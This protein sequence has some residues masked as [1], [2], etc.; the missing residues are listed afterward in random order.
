MNV[1]RLVLSALWALPL[2]AV[3]TPELRNYTCAQDGKSGLVTASF[4]LDEPAIVTM[5]VLTNGVPV[6]WRLYRDGVSGVTLNRVNPAKDYT[7]TW[8][9]SD[10]W[11]SDS[12]SK[13]GAGVVTVEMR[14]WSP[15]NPPDY[16]DID[17]TA[18]SN[19]TYYVSE[20]DLPYAVTDDLY[21]TTHLLMKRM[22]AANRVWQMGS[23]KDGKAESNIG[24]NENLF[25]IVLSSDYYIGVYEFTQGQSVQCGFNVPAGQSVVGDA[26]PLA[27]VTHEDI[28]AVW[29]SA[30]PK[31]EHAVGSGLLSKIQEKT[32]ILVDLPTEA[33]WEFACRGGTTTYFPDGT[34]SNAGVGDYAI[35]SGNAPKDAS[36]NRTCAEVGTKDP[37]FYGLYDMIGN[38]SEFCVEQYVTTYGK[39]FACD[40]K[41]N[42]NPNE[43]DPASA[44]IAFRGSHYDQNKTRA[45]DGYGAWVIPT[46]S[47]YRG[48]GWWTARTS[49]AKHGLRLVAPV[50]RT[51]PK[52]DVST[53]TVSQEPSRRVVIPYSLESTAIVTLELYRNGTRQPD[54]AL[55][56]ICGDVNRLVE[57]DG[58]TKYIYWTPDD[59]WPRQTLATGELSFKIRMWAPDNPPAYMSL[60]LRQSQ[61]TNIAYYA[62]AE[63]MPE[64]ITND[65][66]KTDFLVMRRIPAKDVIWWMGIATN[67]Q[68]KS[69]ED[70]GYDPDYSKRHRVQLSQDF[71]IGV[72][73]LT[74][75]QT[76]VFNNDASKAAQSADW[77]KPFCAQFTALRWRGD[78]GLDWPTDG[79]QVWNSAGLAKF[80][81]RFGLQFDLPTEA[82]WEFACRCGSSDRYGGYTGAQGSFT[83]VGVEALQPVG[84]KA[85]NDWGLYDM[86]GNAGEFC[87]DVSSSSYGLTDEQLA[88]ETPVVDPYG[89]VNPTGYMRVRGGC[90]AS[91]GYV[92][93]AGDRS[94]YH[95][96]DAGSDKYG[97]RLVCPLP[98]AT[99]AEPVLPA[100][101]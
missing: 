55:R 89:A 44:K 87:L 68:G 17:L 73:E 93:R 91:A 28:R 95:H 58:N 45:D 77:T 82:Q 67:A 42:A 24:S 4:S 38:V 36:G 32:G 101:E 92:C 12:P 10:T 78:T 19:V 76:R 2:A 43:N 14:S 25:T 7:V 69:V 11:P 56:A 65:L 59:S 13:L 35:Y 66:W 1:R 16:M 21:K 41:G 99:F 88:S 37:N 33:Q 5:S 23:P 94:V 96:R 27:K 79:H 62:S 18:S 47:A 48:C 31:H 26:Y 53:A 9:P 70:I 61:V 49:D 34:D 52:V 83:W 29:H 97:Y 74:R 6:D 22:H 90:I 60:D 30:W 3:A 40:P 100:A 39:G 46:R 81:D 54:T 84:A 64:P 80:R 57:S 86:L 15:D 51:W 8:R 72:F 85:P 75:R 50:A 20:E 98:G 63:A 71:Y